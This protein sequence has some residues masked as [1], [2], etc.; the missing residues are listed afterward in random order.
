MELI[1]GAA[2]EK[3]AGTGGSSGPEIKL[4]KRFR[5]QWEF[6]DRESFQAA[7]ADDFVHS[8]L[9]DVRSEIV[10]FARCQ[11]QENQPKDD[12]R[13]FLE[14]SIIFIGEVPSRGVAFMAPGAMHHARWMAKVLYAIK[15]WLFRQQFKLTARVREKCERLGTFCSS[16]IPQGLDDH[17]TLCHYCSSQ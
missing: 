3:T 16:G 6:I 4:F 9:A 11:L 15:L 5:D 8:A 1:N 7:P 2:F 13:K 10:E 17:G 12:Y 14:L